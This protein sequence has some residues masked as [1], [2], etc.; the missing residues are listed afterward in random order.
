MFEEFSNTKKHIHVLFYICKNDPIS[1]EF[2]NILMEKAKNGVEVRLLL[3]WAGSLKIKR[4]KIKE[5]KDAGVHFSFSNLPK[6]PTFFYTSQTRNHRK[7]TVIDGKIGYMGGYN[8]GKEYID[9]DPK[10]TPWRDYHL[11]LKGEGVE[12]L[13]RQFLLDWSE[14]SKTN[15]LQNE[16]YFPKLMKGEV[17]HKIISTEGFL[18]EETFSDLIHQAKKSIIIGSP[19]FIP[20]KKLLNDL[21]L[22][23]RRGVTLTLIV[24]YHS[25]HLLVK[26]ASFPYLRQILSNGAKVYQYKKGFYHAKVFMIDEEVCDLGTANFDNRSLFLNHEINCFIHEKKTLNEVFEILKQDIQH[27]Q[28]LRL[29]DLNSLGFSTKVK[30]WIAKLFVHFL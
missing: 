5:L 7:I 23:L 24:P 29:S 10:L 16:I 30:E 6:A 2:L 13:Q 22:A 4:S 20:S 12:D 27:S 9:L 1:Q 3:D 28:E 8:V 21:I 19:Y 17:C 15:L 11:K 14:A 18:L 26:E 25:D